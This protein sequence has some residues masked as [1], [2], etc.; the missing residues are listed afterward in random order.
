MH[1]LYITPYTPNRIRVRSF[2][3]LRALVA[4]G[5]QVTLGALWA[6]D[7]EKR[8]LD[9]LRDLGIGVTARPLR[10]LQTLANS[11][12]ALA[13]PAPLQAHYAWHPGL[14]A[15]LAEIVHTQPLGA[16]HVI[17]VE[18]L[19][20]ARYGL[21]LAKRMAGQGQAIPIVW[22]SVDCISHLF[23]QA[24]QQ[25]SSRASR[26]LTAFELRRTAPYERFLLGQFD[27]T[28]VTSPVDRAALLA[29]WGDPGQGHAAPQMATPQIDVLPN[30]VD[31]AYFCPTE[32]ERL[33]STLVL[34]GKMSYHANVTAARWLV[35]AIMPRVWRTR[36]EVD[37]WIVG[38]DPPP[39]VRALAEERSPGSGRVLVTGTVPD[40]R[41]Y[42]R[43]ATLAV[44]PVPYGAGIQTKVLEAMACAAPVVASPQAVSAL[45]TTDGQEAIVAGDAA[46]FA[47]AIVRLL[48]APAE[49]RRLAQAGRAY[50]EQHHAWASCAARLEAV[51]QERLA[52]K[53]G[54]PI[55]RV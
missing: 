8:D 25:S 43:R 49:R 51:Y 28:L 45:S 15:A 50:V 26:L 52:E 30:G 47:Q 38:K 55:V 6:T 21:Y 12:A 48:D 7:E 9:A 54:S 24:A 44:V 37:V 10:R 46:G 41:P 4:R 19:R 53:E 32:E 40:I 17:H 34:S 2:E 31:L 36:P 11:L 14:A 5:H 29:L 22:D 16:L 1:I 13:G 20:G 42:L 27:H 39:S 35:C 33:P 18:H 3:F 23:R